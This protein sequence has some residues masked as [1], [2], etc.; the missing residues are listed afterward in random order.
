MILAVDGGARRVIFHDGASV[1]RFE[2]INN[3]H[4]YRYG[5]EVVVVV[6]ATPS[7]S[8]RGLTVTMQKQG[9][10]DP[11]LLY[12]WRRLTLDLGVFR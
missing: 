10:L 9:T 3:V 6:V 5:V 11:Q 7:S 8:K 2:R 12:K 1:L 4:L